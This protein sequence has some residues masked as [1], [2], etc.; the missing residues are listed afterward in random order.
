MNLTEQ[1]LE[2]TQLDEH[3]AEYLYKR[4]WD[5]SGENGGV[6]IWMKVLLKLLD[7]NGFS[8]VQRENLGSRQNLTVT[9]DRR[10]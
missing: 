2:V 8:L 10:Y 7:S 4:E 9:R 1:K 5:E 6:I 3:Q